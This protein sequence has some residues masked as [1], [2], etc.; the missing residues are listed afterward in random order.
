[1]NMV[2]SATTRRKKWMKCC[3]TCCKRKKQPCVLIDSF[4]HRRN[5][6]NRLCRRNFSGNL[7]SLLARILVC[8]FTYKATYM[9]T[10]PIY[11]VLAPNVGRAKMMI[12]NLVH[13]ESS[14]TPIAFL[15]LPFFIAQVLQSSFILQ[16][17]SWCAAK[18][19]VLNRR[20]V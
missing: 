9:E 1:M 12:M 14:A 8:Q 13:I 19:G 11:R 10:C 18:P 2:M 20:S 15:S 7:V 6:Q 5:S 3:D 17:L 16:E 4:T